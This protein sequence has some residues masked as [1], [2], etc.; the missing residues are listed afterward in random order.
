MR[1]FLKISANNEMLP[2][3]Y[4][5]L[6]TGVIHKWIGKNNIEH[7]MTSLYSFSWLR[8]TTNN[9]YGIT[10]SQLSYWF[11]SAYNENLI[12]KIINGIQNDPEM[13]FGINVREVLIQET[14]IF[15]N[16]ERFSVANPVFLKKEVDNEIK[17]YYHDN[18]ESDI[19]LTQSLKTKLTSAN[20]DPIGL[21]AAFDRDYPNP[22]IKGFT[23]N[24]IFNKGSICPIIIRGTSEQIAFAWNVGIGNSTGIG[25]G[26]LI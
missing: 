20:I 23:Y 21:N 19:L 8:R 26:A 13:F 4:Q 7:G 1:L 3:N 14:P 15:S 18:K 2:F 12:R 16:T 6:L 24:N 9:K 25:F 17:F 5:P 22:K 10:T 11:I